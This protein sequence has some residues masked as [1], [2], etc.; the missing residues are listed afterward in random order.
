MKNIIISLSIVVLSFQARGQSISLAGTWQVKLDSLNVG[1]GENWQNKTLNGTSIKLPGTLDAARIGKTPMLDTMVM[2]KQVMLSLARKHRYVGVAW[3][4][5]DIELKEAFTGG[6]LSLER[7]LWSTDCW[8]DGKMIGRSESLSTPHQFN[9]PALNPGK[10][11]ILLRIDN[12]RQYD[13]S[14]NTFAHAYTDGT[15]IIWNGV[16]GNMKIE[17]GQNYKLTNLQ[18]HANPSTKSVTIQTG[19]SSTRTSFANQKLKYS[20]YRKNKLIYQTLTPINKNLIEQ[21]LITTSLKLKEVDLWDEFNPSL[22]KAVVEVVS[23]GKPALAK[24]SNFA[25]R[26]LENANGLLSINGRRVFLRGTLDCNIYP[27]EGHPPMD[28]SSWVKVFQ[29]IKSY[30][31]NHVRY[32]SWCPPEAAFQVADSLGLYLQVELPLWSLKVGEDAGTR[33]FLEQESQQIIDNFGNHP[34]FCLWSMG[35]ELE[36]NFEWL[37]NLVAKLKA[38]DDRRL[39]AATSFSFQKGKGLA[40][41]VNDDFLIAQYTKKGWVRGQGVF[42]SEKPNFDKDYRLTADSIPVPLISHEIGQYSVFPSLNEIE[43]YTGVLDPLNFKAVR[44]DMQKKGMIAL[45]DTF[46][47]ASGKFAALLYK[48]EIE[49][50]LKT[51]SFSGF[52]LLDLH[53]FPGQGTALVGLLDAFWQSKGLISPAKFKEFC[54]EVVPLLRFTKAAYLN[55]EKFVGSIAVA[56]FAAQPID[57]TISWQ[58]RTKNAQV[59]FTGKSD[60]QRINIGTGTFSEINIPLSQVTSATELE[61]IVQIDGT[62]YKNSWHFWVYPAKQDTQISDV[63]FTN[64]KAEAVQALRTGRSVVL[65]PDTAKLNGVA[66]RF[67]SVF[68]SPVHFPDQPGTMGLLCDVKHPALAEFPTAYHSDWQWW[69]LV[70]NSKTILIDS[71]NSRDLSIVTVI[72]NFFKNRK[73]ANIIE[74]RVGTGK[75]ILCSMDISNNLSKRIEAR[76]L[77][78]SILTYAAGGSF[79][80]KGSISEKELGLL[81]KE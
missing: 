57:G 46:K 21:G 42:N 7:V 37:N 31:L 10:H 51:N 55:D 80:P 38:Q 4:Q 26:K 3:Y 43:K 77:R 19:L 67:T 45:A 9:L 36:G 72:D 48:E 40:P 73:M 35:N 24:E 56:N 25:F 11:T 33:S 1:I 16:I 58:V 63:L 6:Q 54:S 29:T 34:S 41:E 32:H 50:A 17:G 30:G 79:N 68:W 20:I 12:T 27:L 14:F 39:Y 76:Q 22:Y 53:D 65:N 70:T 81:V 78:K 66:G 18:I 28:K 2:N 49:R 44:H 69:D 5:R 64:S 61:I 75:L 62:P 13:I 52:Q 47:M 15:Q 60:K 23:S 59:L 71:L 8:I 74:A